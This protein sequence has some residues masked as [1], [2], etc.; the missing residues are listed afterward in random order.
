MLH[1][2]HNRKTLLAL[3]LSLSTLTLAGCGNCNNDNAPKNDLGASVATVNG[4]PVYKSEF[5]LYVTERAQGVTPGTLTDAHRKQLLEELINL[6]L[7]ANESRQHALTGNADLEVRLRLQEDNLLAQA[8][9][10]QERENFAPTEA[11]QKAEYEQALPAIASKQYKA[12]H[13]LVPEKAQADKLLADIKAGKDFDE[14]AKANSIDGSASKGGDLGWFIA[15]Q[16][17]E[18]FA[19]AVKALEVGKMSDAPVK[20]QFGWHIIKLDDTRTVEPPKFEDM[21]ERII[22]ALQMEYI[23]EYVENLRKTADIQSDLLDAETESNS[24][25][26]VGETQPAE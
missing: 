13:I 20:T 8:L 21:Q 14:L 19:N 24:A 1:M 15:T 22:G 10:R 6:K 17:V 2:L 7:I 5:D 12:R 26:E 25:V 16:M 3:T 9:I 4:Q 18:P 23:E 11:A